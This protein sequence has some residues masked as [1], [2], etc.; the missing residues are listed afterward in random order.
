MSTA[1]QTAPVV[2]LV[3]DN[4]GDVHLTRYCLKKWGVPVDLRVAEDG[5]QALEYLRE[6]GEQDAYRL[7][8]LMLLDLNLPFKDGREVLREIRADSRTSIMPVVIFTSS[9][10]PDDVRALY[11]AGANSYV[12]K[13]GDLVEYQTLIETVFEF[14]LRA[15]RVPSW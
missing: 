8:V 2:L 13:P 11:E 10:N 9:Q 6:A 14:W 3:E 15:A 5:L 4:P 1:V 7:P 12:S